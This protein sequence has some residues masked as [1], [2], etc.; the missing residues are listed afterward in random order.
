MILFRLHSKNT[1]G[2]HE[3]ILKTQFL[4]VFNV[5]RQ[6]LIQFWRF[7]LYS[8]IL[9]KNK[10]AIDKKLSYQSSNVFQKMIKA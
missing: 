3:T 2:P 1:S 6:K 5:T 9:K 7:I 4:Q 10:N 8:Q